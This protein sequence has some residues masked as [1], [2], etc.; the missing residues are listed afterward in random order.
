MQARYYA[1]VIGRFYS[2]DPVGT[3]EFIMSGDIHGFNRHSYVGNNSYKYTDPTGMS[4]EPTTTIIVNKKP[5]TLKGPYKSKLKTLAHK[6]RIKVGGA[7]VGK[8]TLGTVKISDLG[9][10]AKIGLKKKNRA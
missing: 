8:L 1:P 4:K 9:R 5:L 7:A 10:L 2:N 3:K 6:L